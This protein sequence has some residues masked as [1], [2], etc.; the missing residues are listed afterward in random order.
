[1][2]RE[3]IWECEGLIFDIAYRYLCQYVQVGDLRVSIFMVRRLWPKFSR[4]NAGDELKSAWLTPI[5]IN[6]VDEDNLGGK[7]TD[8]GIAHALWEGYGIISEAAKILK[9][10]RRT[11]CDALGRSPML[12]EIIRECEGQIFDTAYENVCHYVEK[13]NLTAAIF[14]YRLLQPKFD[15][16][17]SE[18]I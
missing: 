18:T 5:E 2:L 17:T 4:A 15:S 1:M 14:L 13:G 9:C 11:I 6:N 8:E 16:P 12:R 10:S 3:I 7:P